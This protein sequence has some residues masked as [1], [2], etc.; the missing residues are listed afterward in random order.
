MQLNIIQAQKY[1]TDILK[2]IDKICQREKIHYFVYFGTL[3]GAV[4]HNGPIPWDY[5]VDIFV[6]EPE[7][8]RFVEAM[9]KYLPVE[10]W[11]NY[12]NSNYHWRSFARI[13][14]KGYRTESLHVDVFRL[15]GLPKNDTERI[16]LLRKGK[17]LFILWKAKVVDADFYYRSSLSMRIKAKILKFLLIPISVKKILKQIDMIC[18]KYDYY[19]SEFVGFPLGNKNY[20]LRKV[21][22]E[23]IIRVNYSNF[24]INIPKNY[25]K[26]LTNIYG[27]YLEYPSIDEQNRGI[28]KILI[29]RK[30][31]E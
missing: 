3:I 17:V 25:D 29:V 7:M 22:A 14:L 1:T 9:E 10:F 15:C 11:I 26:L 28:N 19:T 23:N 27:N 20:T 8:D 5:D 18:N 31:A 13:G 4:R 16:K 30:Y 2:E 6:P 24:K 21:D 12:R